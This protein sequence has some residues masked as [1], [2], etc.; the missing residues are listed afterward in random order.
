MPSATPPAQPVPAERQS[1]LRTLRSPRLLKVEIL[2]GLVTALALIPE[3]M[4]FAIIAGVD[5]RVGLYASVVMAISIAFVGGRPAMVSGGAG[6]TALVIAPLVAA[7][8]LDYFIAA[9][10]LA[11]VF[12]VLLAVVGVAKLMRFI[13]RSVMIGFVNGLAILI[14]SSQFPEL[15]GVPG[16]VYPL[17]GLGLLIV[18][19][20]PKLTRA[21]PA[22]FVTIVVL[23]VITA[24]FAVAVPTVSDRGELP[25]SLPQLFIPEVP[26]TLETFQIIAPY[27]LGMAFVGL[28]ESLMTG[29]LVDD[30]TD[31]H[32]NKTR[33]S[34]G[35]GVSNMLSGFT[36]GM[37]GCAMIG[38]TMIN[39]KAAGARTRIS[40]FLAGVFILVLVLAMGEVVGMIPMAA[41]VAVMVF[42]SFITFDWHSIAPGTLKAMPK[43]ETTVMLVT[44]ATTVITHNLAI[45]VGVG[46]LTAMVLFAH[47]VSR[48]AQVHREEHDGDSVTYRVEGEL[49]FASSNDLYYQFDYAEDPG[50]VVINFA[51]SHLWDASTVAALD[52]VVRKYESYGK[53]VEV[54]GL[55][56][57]SAQ[58]RER[59]TGRLGS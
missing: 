23:T 14:F 58:M 3:S 29:K 47:R 34:W 55:N 2:A 48:F 43:S 25:D 37:G 11:G 42:V 18:F 36:G 12:Q 21:V 31:T 22:P 39:V 46:V 17:V 16:L 7:Y 51:D 41:L 4:A 49:F 9:V 50:H 5:P 30:I 59:L 6:A 40:T 33:E 45:G 56:E 15:I 53:Y 32:S 20:F 26:L 24:S 1:V 54:T 19:L 10:I 38:Q 27:A 44:T 28:L 13:P 35:Q 52:S 8:G 57:A